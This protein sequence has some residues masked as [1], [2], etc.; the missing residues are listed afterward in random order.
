VT[1]LEAYEAALASSLSGLASQGLLRRLRLPAGIDLAS[2]DYLG[3]A[4]DPRLASR[5]REAL[6]DEPTGAGGSRLLGGHREIFERLEQR[7]ASFSGSPS[8]LLFGSGYLANVGLLQA[9]LGKGDLVLSD[10]LN[11]ASLIDGIR[12]SGARKVVYPH[13]DLRAAAAALAAPRTGRTVIVTESVFSMEGDRAPL[14]DLVALAAEQDALL[15]VDEA[16]ATGLYGQR[17]SGL[18][19]EL[20]VRDGVLATIHTGGKALGA[21]G[22]WVAG[23]TALKDHLVNRARTFVFTTAPLP[24]LAAALE[25][26]LDILGMEGWRAEEVHRKAALLRAALQRRGLASSGD[27]PIVPLLVGTPEAALALEKGLSEAG[28][29]ARAVRPPTVPPGTCRIRVSVRL[30]V[31]DHELERFASEA[32][33]ILGAEAA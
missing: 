14:R 16:H 2:N 10:E 11:H 8:A 17:R 5:V 24:I 22:A 30:P 23:S 20:G 7:L 33:R 32:S 21:A 12:L 28:F 25:A 9:V 26:S 4:G 27:T 3:L 6:G 13:L 1:P 15:I 29:D 18:V 31:P 19:E